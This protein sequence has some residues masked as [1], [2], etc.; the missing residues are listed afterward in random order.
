LAHQLNLRNFLFVVRLAI[1][2]LVD[3]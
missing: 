1:I 3:P 2:E